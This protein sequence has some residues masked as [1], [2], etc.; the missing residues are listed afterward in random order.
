MAVR[1]QKNFLGAY[2]VPKESEAQSLVQALY[3]FS[4]GVSDLGK[5]LGKK[6]TEQTDLSN[7]E[8]TKH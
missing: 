7:L 1:Y 5:G 4:S 3:S 2:S 6:I 8:I